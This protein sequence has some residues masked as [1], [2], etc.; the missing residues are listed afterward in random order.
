MAPE[1][2]R[3]TS[4]AQAPALVHSASACNKIFR[5]SHLQEYKLRFGEGVHFEDVYV[6]L[7]A[8]LWSRETVLT[9]T[10]TYR[11]R[12]RELSGSIMDSLFSEAR[13]FEDHLLAE[14]MLA[15]LMPQLDEDRAAALRTFMVRSFQGFLLRAPE[16]LEHAALADFFR[17]AVAVYGDF[18]PEAVTASA[19]NARHRIP[20]AAVIK[21]DF[22]LFARRGEHA[23]R[24]RAH[25]GRLL[26]DRYDDLDEVMHLDTVHAW[27]ESVT[28]RH[29]R[30]VVF[31]GRLNVPGLDL[32]TTSTLDI[33]LR[34]R[35]SGVTVPARVIERP[36]VAARAP[37]LRYSGFEAVVPLARLKEGAHHIRLVFHTPTGQASTRTKPS[38]GYLRS[39]RH[40][41][42]AG[43]SLLPRVDRWDNCQLVVRPASTP[44]ERRRLSRNLLREDFAALRTKAPFGA[45]RVLRAL[46]RP[47]M[48]RKKVWLLGERRD[49]T[50]DNSAALFTHLRQHHPHLP[51][52]Y[53]L[54]RKA[55]GF[56]ELSVLGNVVAHSSRRHR[57]LMLHAAVLVNS[58]D[59]DAYMLPDGWS[60]EQY[61]RHLAWRVGSRRVFLQHGVIYNDVSH[62]LHRGVTGFDLFCT[63]SDREAAY[64]R[65]RMDYTDQVVTTGLAR[66]DTLVKPD[67]PRPRVLFMPTWRSY[68]VSPSYA[69]SRAAREALADSAYIHFLREFLA[70]PL[71]QAGL[72]RY[73][74]TLEF[75]PHYEVGP[76]VKDLA[77]AQPRYLFSD[78]KSR[79]IQSAIRECSVFVTDWSSTFFDAAYLGTPVVLCPFDPDDF[80]SRHYRRGYFDLAADGFG[81]VAM[82]PEAA[83]SAVLRQ[84]HEDGAMQELYAARAQSFFTHRD[85]SNAERIVEAIASLR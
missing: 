29:G 12:K 17:R 61:Q 39:A 54:D 44:A 14:E 22:D 64:V 70:S 26:L 55:P 50:Q 74:A 60:R 21:R 77:E 69:K 9:R 79:N 40:H 66:F 73:D 45:Q 19:L 37:E 5:R 68:L 10:V 13:N 63:S 27:L 43:L 36:D 67:R 47:F 30:E 62:A 83:V 41:R 24:V 65:E 42:R 80:H 1:P 32:S 33:G 18:P 53:V 46:T 34:V 38:Q 75:L 58:Y 85:R 15:D 76:H 78:P 4:L 23:T 48:R 3:I 28:V 31:T 20:Y 35:G 81:P 59:I 2:R 71:L 8:L 11:Y 49:T 16:M 51:V 56:T 72:E 82:D 52:Y 7:P 6:T 57:W 84:L 25:D